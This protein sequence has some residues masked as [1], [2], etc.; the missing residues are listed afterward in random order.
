MNIKQKYENAKDKI[1]RHPNCIAAMGGML[2]AAA[3]LGYASGKELSGVK[4][5]SGILDAVLGDLADG[6]K[7]AVWYNGSTLFVQP[8]PLSEEDLK[9]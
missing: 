9:N 4:K 8:E 1:A 3:A 5:R 2:I 6:E 7:H